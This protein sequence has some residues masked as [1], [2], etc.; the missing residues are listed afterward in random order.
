MKLLLTLLLLVSCGHDHR[1]IRYKPKDGQNGTSCSTRNDTVGVYIE[2]TDGS[3]TFIPYPKD[4]KDGESIQGQQGEPGQPGE[5]GQ[6]CN[7]VNRNETCV[8]HTKKYDVY[9]VCPD[10]EELIVKKSVRNGC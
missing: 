9:L 8:H 5:N 7:L 3:E 4:G 2:C 6:D 1:F 10:S